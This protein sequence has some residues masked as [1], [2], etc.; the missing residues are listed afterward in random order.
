MLN[1]FINGQIFLC[2][3]LSVQYELWNKFHILKKIQKLTKQ[4]KKDRKEKEK[5]RYKA[6]YYAQGE[7]P[8]PLTHLPPLFTGGP[9][10]ASR[11]HG[12]SMSPWRPS[13]LAWGIRPP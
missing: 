11:G 1:E 7:P 12:H 3:C 4:I 6:L 2:H 8:P 9:W 10:Q 13:R 5:K